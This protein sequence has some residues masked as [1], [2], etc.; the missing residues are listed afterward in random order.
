MFGVIDFKD[1][2]LYIYA[3]L[4]S[5][6]SLFFRINQGKDISV[7][8]NVNK[9]LSLLSYQNNLYQ[10]S[11]ESLHLSHS[12]ILNVAILRDEECKC[13]ISSALLNLSKKEIDSLSLHY[14]VE[15]IIYND[16]KCSLCNLNFKIWDINENYGYKGCVYNPC[17]YNVITHDNFKESDVGWGNKDKIDD[18]IRK[19][20]FDRSKIYFIGMRGEL[21]GLYLSKNPIPENLKHDSFICW[22]CIKSVENDLNFI[23][24]H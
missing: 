14:K 3:D 22:S 15:R 21:S 5:A 9:S 17:Y 12:T 16:K 24:G 1:S 19:L 11:L 7:Q 6:I 10:V 18:E 8:P 23:W 4:S 13:T 2:K 20:N